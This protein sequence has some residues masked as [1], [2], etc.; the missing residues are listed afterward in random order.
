M[1]FDELYRFHSEIKIEMKNRYLKTQ[2][3]PQSEDVGHVRH[4]EEEKAL[5][6]CQRYILVLLT[7]TGRE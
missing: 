6:I 2:E 3:V 1:V 4:Q 7:R 5:T